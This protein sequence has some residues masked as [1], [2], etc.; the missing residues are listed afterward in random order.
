[1]GVDKCVENRGKVFNKLIWISRRNTV[2]AS[3]LD[4]PNFRLGRFFQTYHLRKGVFLYSLDRLSRG[5]L[6]TLRIIDTMLITSTNC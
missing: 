5:K 6:L 4:Y 2:L 3:L 1:M